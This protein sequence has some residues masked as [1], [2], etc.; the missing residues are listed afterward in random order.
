MKG[1]LWRS[2]LG[3]LLVVAGILSILAGVIATA[4]SYDPTTPD[5]DSTRLGGW[6]FIGFGLVL[7]VPGILLI[8]SGRRIDRAEPKQP[9]PARRFTK[10]HLVGYSA[11]VLL[12]VAFGVGAIIYSFSLDGDLQSFRSSHRCAA[13]P[14]ANCYQLRDVVIT[15]VDISHGRGGETDTVRFSD[16]GFSQE[17]AIH[18][19][20][21]DSSVLRTG[22]EAVAT[23][24]RGKYTNLDVSGVSFATFDNPV[25]QRGEWRLIGFTVLGTVLLQ[26]V[27]FGGG[28]LYVR[29]RTAAL[30]PQSII[31]K[32]G[33]PILPLVLH[34]STRKSQ[35]LV[36]LVA[37]PVGLA[38]LYFYLAQYGRVVQWTIGAAS[39]LLLAWGAIWQLV[40]VPRSA[41]YVDDLSFGTVGGLGRRKSW[42]RSEAA[43]V[44]LKSLHRGKRAPA[45]PLVVVVGPDGR[46]RMKFSALLC[47]EEAPTQFAAALRVPLDMDS[48]ETPISPVQLEKEIPASVSW[49]MRHATALGAGIAIVLIAVISLA[50]GLSSGPSHR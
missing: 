11:A 35:L 7:A 23:V 9:R 1:G 33:Y 16:S 20:G 4:A 25:G 38:G 36:W 19:G 10:V 37:V 30:P 40:L 31:G 47:D 45:L 50:V 24:W 17:V 28:V 26:L 15:G 49:G 44:V 32:T 3:W 42:D 48:L 34:P 6:I 5:A 21:L 14:D 27:V 39:A 18:P 43:R 8:R 41:I 46:A 22:A 29:R 12:G 2:I 13:A